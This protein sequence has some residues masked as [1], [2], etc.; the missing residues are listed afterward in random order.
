LQ[1]IEGKTTISNDILADIHIK[2]L[3]AYMQRAKKDQALFENITFAFA[4][5]HERFKEETTTSVEA[6][7]ELLARRTEAINTTVDG[8]IH[9]LIE[10]EEHAALKDVLSK[11]MSLKL[12]A[13]FEKQNALIFDYPERLRI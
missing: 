3:A 6:H 2:P 4:S 8:H 11:D 13:L 5:E 12:H 9:A 1:I 7:K 10:K